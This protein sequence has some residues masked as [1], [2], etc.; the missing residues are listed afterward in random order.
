[1]TIGDVIT[2]ALQDLT[3]LAAGESPS[4]EDMDLALSRVNDWI[5]SLQNEGLTLYTVTRT[6]WTITTAA[7]YTVGTGATVN[8]SRPVGPE[9]IL[10]IGYQDTSV[11]PTLERLQGPV[12]TED[13]YAGLAQK[14]LTG[15]YPQ[16]WYYNPTMATGTLRPWPVPTS[17]TL[18][19]VLYSKAAISEFA[20][21]ATTITLPPGYRR[22]FRS[23]LTIEL[24]AAFTKP[25][26]PQVATIAVTSKA[27]IKRV[28][29]RA[30]DM[31]VDRALLST[32]RYDINRGY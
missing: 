18:Q 16:V 8:V 4:D 15:V 17:S 20:T 21:A 5:D 3:V 6:T 12:L 14:T 9:A 24:A 25:I 7:S 28:N 26:P 30:S 29:H 10:N 1:V 22:F 27:A 32:G 23:H 31:S 11:S 13:A 19:G 2:G